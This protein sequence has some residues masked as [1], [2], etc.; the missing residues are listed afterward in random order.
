MVVEFVGQGNMWEEHQLGIAVEEPDMVAVDTGLVGKLV[1][2]LG[3]G[4]GQQ[5]DMELEQVAGM[6]LDQ[7]G[8]EAEQVGKEAEQVGKEAEQVGLVA[9]QVG[10]AVVDSLG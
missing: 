9:E 10:I 4:A 1:G 7:V 6:E 5:V 2:W 3:M 8:K